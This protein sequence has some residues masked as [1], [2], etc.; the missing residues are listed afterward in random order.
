[1]GIFYASLTAE[2]FIPDPF[3][4]KPG[5]RLYQT[6]DLA[7]YLPDGSIEFLGRVDHQ[8]KIHGVRV[9]LGEIELY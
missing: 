5:E 6:G 3:S 7:R 8:V 4:N 1:M 2:R 9:E